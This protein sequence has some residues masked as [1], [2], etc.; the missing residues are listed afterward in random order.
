[1]DGS[2]DAIMVPSTGPKT[3]VL[4]QTF[5]RHPDPGQVLVR[6]KALPIQLGKRSLESCGYLI[7]RCHASYR[8]AFIR[9]S[10]GELRNLDVRGEPDFLQQP[11]AVVV[12]IEL[13]PGE[14]V[15]R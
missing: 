5:R 14:A 4:K 11:N 3:D 13:I 10:G 8:A 15:T 6:V 7:A 1:M 2:A 12:R 9:I